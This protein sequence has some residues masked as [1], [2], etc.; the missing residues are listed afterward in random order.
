MSR[1]FSKL[2]RTSHTPVG[3]DV[4]S[5]NMAEVVDATWHDST[6]TEHTDAEHDVLKRRKLMPNTVIMLPGKLLE[7]TIPPKLEFVEAFEKI[8][9]PLV[10]WTNK[11]L[12]ESLKYTNMLQFPTGV[13]EFIW[14]TTSVNDTTAQ[15]A[16]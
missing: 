14:T 10:I 2:M 7:G 9:M 3:V 8:V 4:D 16:G 15:A 5:V 6:A 1:G 13:V 11:F 12:L